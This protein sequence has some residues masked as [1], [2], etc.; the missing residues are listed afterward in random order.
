MELKNINETIEDI[1][2][3]FPNLTI[4]EIIKAI[5]SGSL[6]KYGRPFKLST[7][8]ICFWIREYKKEINKSKLSL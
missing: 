5:R 7:T 4:D 8:E 6:A 2:I 1:Y 3:E